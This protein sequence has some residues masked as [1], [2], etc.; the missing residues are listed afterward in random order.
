MKC[1]VRMRADL[2]QV[3]NSE[4]PYRQ[5]SATM[6][7]IAARRAGRPKIHMSNWFA[8][9]KSKEDGICVFGVLMVNQRR[10]GG[11]WS[12]SVDALEIIHASESVDQRLKQAAVVLMTNR[13]GG[14]CVSVTSVSDLKKRLRGIAPNPGNGDYYWLDENFNVREP[15]NPDEVAGEGEFPI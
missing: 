1:F 11:H 3:S 7:E 6:M 4:G 9:H 14:T 13:R 12:L 10:P 8:Y 15:G 5:Y 2:D